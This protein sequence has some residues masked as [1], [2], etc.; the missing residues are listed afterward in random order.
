MKK[1][2]TILLV[3]LVI[4]ICLAIGYVSYKKY[5][6]NQ[7]IKRRERYNEI[8]EDVKSAVEWN[9]KATHPGCLISKRFNKTTSTI[10][11]FNSSILINNGYIKKDQLLDIDNE[12]YCDVY[13]KINQFLENSL[14]YQHNC[15]LYY[16]IY[17]KCNDYEEKG[18]INWE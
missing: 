10:N 12:S 1:K 14:D 3:I 18:Y 9:L 17:L 2:K 6:V 13:V 16:K 5:K 4:M 7:E 8:R 15:E 11:F